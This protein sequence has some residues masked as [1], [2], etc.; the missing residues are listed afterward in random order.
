MLERAPGLSFI[1]TR[2]VESGAVPK[3]QFEPQVFIEKPDQF[4]RSVPGKAVGER[5]QL[6]GNYHCESP[7]CTLCC[8]D[9]FLA[10]MVRAL[11]SHLGLYG[12]EGVLFGR[13]LERDKTR[14][15]PRESKPTGPIVHFVSRLRII[16]CEE[17]LKLS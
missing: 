7:R 17:L 8:Y 14:I 12:R 3:R 4:R 11:D 15:S 6:C 2:T 10:L 16:T 13:T 1:I 5:G 9:I